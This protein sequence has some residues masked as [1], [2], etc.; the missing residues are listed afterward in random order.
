VHEQ[1]SDLGGRSKGL[2]KAF[3][4]SVNWLVEE[5]NKILLLYRCILI[6]IQFGENVQ[7]WHWGRIHRSTFAH[8]LGK[9]KPFNLGTLYY[10][11]RESYYVINI[12]V[13]FDVGPQPVDGDDDTVARSG[14]AKDERHRKFDAINGISFR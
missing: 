2:R 14:F 4:D 6:R 1:W 5:V 8:L 10:Y 9:Q 3:R 11:N 12:V 7:D 13:V